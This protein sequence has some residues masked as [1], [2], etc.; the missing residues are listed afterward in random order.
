M[1]LL[2]ESKLLRLRQVSEVEDIDAQQRSRTSI[3]GTLKDPLRRLMPS[4]NLFYIRIIVQLT[5]I[6]L[7]PICLK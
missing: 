7:R 5:Y 3:Q 6:L 2:V 4:K 1:D